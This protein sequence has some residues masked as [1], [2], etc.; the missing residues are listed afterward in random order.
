M[1]ENLPPVADRFVGRNHELR[2]LDAV[3]AAAAQ[4]RGSVTVVSGEPG[5]G[6][7]R[8]CEQAAARAR[9]AGLTV[10]EARCWV[11]GGAPALWPWQPILRGLGGDDAADLLGSDSGLATV[12]PDRFAR[13]AA[14]TDRL[15][16]ASARA[17]VC[18][19]IDDVHAADAGTLLLLRFV[20]RSL[21]GLRVAVVLA[22][23]AGEPAPD[24]LE[25][26]LLD[27]IEAEATPIV[28]GRFDTAE[29][30]ALLGA[31]GLDDLDP[32][33]LL[34]VV[35]VSGG[36][37]LYLRRIAA[38][39]APHPQR[40]IPEGLQV[41]IE[42]S[43]RG[44]SEPA[45]RML[46]ASAV[47]GLTVS[48]A[49]AAAVA[50]AE[51]ATVLDAVSE[52]ATVGL[53]VAEGTDRFAF[54]HEL[55]RATLEAG[56]G[57]SDRLDAH[58]RATAAVGGDAPE[59]PQER[60]A[61]RAHHALAAAP[62]SPDDA[63]LAV[64][65]CRTAARSMMA[66][67]AYE[68][69]DALVSS[70]LKLHDGGALG[71]PPG[72]LLLEWAQAALSCGR[73][74]DARVRFDRAATAAERLDLPTDLAE[75]ALGLGGHWVNE[76]RGPLERARVLGLQRS[77]LDRLPEDALALQVRLEARLAAEAVYD[78][79]RVE[80]VFEVLARARSVGDP[81]A[82]AEVLSMVH[83]ALLAPDYAHRRLDLAD[84]LIRVAS[85]AGHGV[86]GLMG[87]CWRT[88]DLFLLGD[89]GAVRALEDLRLRADALACQNIL[90][91][92]DVLDVMLQARAGRLDEAEASAQRAYDLGTAVGEADALA[93]LGAHT[94]VIRWIQGRDTELLETAESVAASATLPPAEF[95]FRAH[96]ASIAA[97]SGHHDRAR[98]ALDQLAA[99]G[100]AALPR[101]S[102]WLVGLVA[103]VDTAAVLSDEVIAREAYDLLLPFAQRPAMPSLAVVCLGSTERWLGLA[104]LTFGELDRS[105]AH[106]E[107]SLDANRRLANLP[108]VAIAEADLAD[109]LRR[110]DRPGDRARASELLEQAIAAAEGMDMPDRVASWHAELSQL[111]APSPSLRSGVLRREGRGWLVAVD[112][113]QAFVADLIGMTYLARLLRH[114]GQHVAALTLTLTGTVASGDSH[115]ELLDDQA[116]AAYAARAQEL[117]E[118]LAEAEAH[119]DLGRSEQLRTELDTLVDQLEAAIGL[120]GQPRSFTNPAERARTAVRK[121][122]RRAID[123]I[124]AVDPLVG[125]VLRSAITTG[126]TCVYTPDP[127][128]P[129]AW[130]I[131]DS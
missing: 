50:V 60:L 14:V 128:D 72:G 55:V 69:A 85:E 101:S 10:V 71:P 112:D 13:F 30:S 43:L 17:P 40:G 105:V 18:L 54:S 115:H 49:E 123:E 103:I 89:P 98:R 41:A 58:A 65:A 11:D 131:D 59:V 29:S 86:L 21:P 25:S 83:H 104:A 91:I 48:V 20:T 24:R 124:D 92:V 81:G 45:R 26:R 109:G 67:F 22:R 47:L 99:G 110:R 61:R 16:T 15:A 94:Q 62:R 31:N 3:C 77:A 27:D 130:S 42:R 111:S 125:R 1:G 23:R 68:Q 5:I 44:L 122:L 64:D 127:D 9:D 8:L 73:L 96:A 38:L 53:V 118:E 95:G 88:V 90:Y 52:A 106:L 28:L 46:P 35:R 4:G 39:G 100:L 63:R 93:Y 32:D 76:Q 114:P 57:S 87:L 102:S 2:H 36:N 80:P 126:S 56:L 74:A 107:R 7:T 129:I 121:A 34:A 108:L 120:H 12:D 78:G 116:R 37:P 51:P 117:R 113:H 79:G 33:L 84:E 19:I 119:A 6:K 75:A 82:L 97:R 70:A 66:S